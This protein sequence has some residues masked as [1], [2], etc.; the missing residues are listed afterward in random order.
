MSLIP[1]KFVV[2]VRSGVCIPRFGLVLNSGPK[3]TTLF[4]FDPTTQQY[5][6]G[7]VQLENGS[8]QAL[9]SPSP[10]SN[11]PHF[12]PLQPDLPPSQQVQLVPSHHL[13][14]SSKIAS[15]AIATSTQ[16]AQ[17]TVAAITNHLSAPSQQQPQPLQHA[18]LSS[19]PA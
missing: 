10:L 15:T 2:F 17:V 5:D 7:S 11:L 14:A 8:L 16:S 13:T 9:P 3:K 19:Q 1:A 6:G 4:L 12:A 18:Q